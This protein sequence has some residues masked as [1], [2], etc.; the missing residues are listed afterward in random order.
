[1]NKELK[2]SP[3]KP[4][5]LYR[6]K[7][8]K[9]V[10]TLTKNGDQ[11]WACGECGSLYTPWGDGDNPL[12][13]AGEC[14]KQNYCSCGNKIE[15]GYIGPKCSPCNRFEGN[16]KRLEES[17]EIESFDGPVFN[18]SSDQYWS[19][20][21]DFEDWAQDLIDVGEE[22]LLPEWIYPC[23]TKGFPK[24]DAWDLIQSYIEDEHH[25]DAGDQIEGVEEFQKFLDSWCAKQTLESWYPNYKQ[26]INVSKL[27]KLEVK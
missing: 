27:L 24:L 22:D 25:E 19:D 8:K 15:K 14:C 26:K 7:K 18:D 4:F 13:R 12:K 16:Q 3:K 11:I 10:R 23:T 2:D 5:S 17:E 9:F 6:K 20:L 21:G 1:M